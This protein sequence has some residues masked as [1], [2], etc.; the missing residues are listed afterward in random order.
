M[1]LPRIVAL[2]AA[3]LLLLLVVGKVIGARTGPTATPTSSGTSA[4]HP[5]VVQLGDSCPDT[6]GPNGESG[7]TASAIPNSDGWNTYVSNQDVGWEGVGTQTLSATSASN[8]QVVSDIGPCGGCVQTFPNTQ[9]LFDNWGAGGWN[10]KANPPLSAL[11]ALKVDYAETS[12]GGSANA[13][14]FAADIWQQ[15]Y[16]SDV[17]FWVDT[18]GRCHDTDGPDGGVLGHFSMDG[19]T[20]TAHRYGGAGAEIILVLDG[21]GG[22]G[23]CA[24]QSSGTIDIKGGMEWLASHG[25]IPSAPVITQVNTGWEITQS[26]KARFSLHRYAIT[27]T[28]K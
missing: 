5:C 2:A 3:G 23:T 27:A 12:P 10:G 19:Q 8:W 20:W 11:S 25:F 9:Q 17:M 18:N 24:Q 13:Y 15:G 26:K 16:E 6:S 1:T 22:P 4:A 14:E 7:Y 28:P 21:P